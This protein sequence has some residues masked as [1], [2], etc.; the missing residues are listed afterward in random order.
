MIGA[1]PDDCELF[2]GGLAAKYV[3]MGR[4]VKFVSLTNGDAGHH[5]QGGGALARRRRSESMEAGRV[6]DIEYEVLDHHDGE[7]VPSLDVRRDV[8]RLI[9]D[10]QADVVLSH[11]PYDYHPDHRYTGM[12]VQDAAYMVAVPNICP[13]A[14]ALRH[15]PFF[16]YLWDPFQKPY[17]FQPDASVAVDEVMDLKWKMIHCHQSQFYEWLPYV[18]GYEEAVP[19][20]VK[21]RFAWLKK[22]W[23]PMMQAMTACSRK[24]HEKRYGKS[25]AAKHKFAECFEICEYGRT[26]TAQ[27]LKMIFPE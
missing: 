20:G 21:E 22:T 17:P 16:F 23:S 2:A 1:H 26:P 7:L 15:N 12:A 27:D 11:R 5:L 10:W 19:D 6:L 24:T 9:R 18:D 25:K 4:A 8:I 13:A 14:I 3:C